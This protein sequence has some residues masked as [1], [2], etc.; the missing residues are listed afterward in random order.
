MR[1]HWRKYISNGTRNSSRRTQSYLDLKEIVARQALVVHFM[2]G[3]L[4]VAAILI[5]N[6]GESFGRVGENTVS[7][8]FD[9]VQSQD[10]KVVSLT[11]CCWQIVALECRIA[12]A[13]RSC[14]G[15]CQ[16][17][18]ATQDLEGR[19]IVSSRL[20]KVFFFFIQSYR[21]SLNIDF[22]V[23]CQSKDD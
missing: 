8:R 21:A 2:V 3:I 19:V 13:C 16:Y 5:L 14:F 15:F 11:V 20:V 1:A 22:L 17:F 9:T 23:F 7:A 12:R 10:V 4:R 18:K 6:K